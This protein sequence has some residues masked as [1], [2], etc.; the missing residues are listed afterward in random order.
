VAIALIGAGGQL[1]GDLMEL[2]AGEEVFAFARDQLDLRTPE[3]I[4]RRLDPLNIETV[5]NTAAYNLV[6]RAESA[7]LEAFETNYVGAM[8]LARYC[9]GRG[10]RLVHFSTD[11]VFGLDAE[12]DAPWEVDDAPGPVSVYGAS[13]LAG[14]YAVRT[15]ASNHLVVRTCGLYGRRG[16]RG[17]GGNFVETMLRLAESGKPL[18]IVDDQTCTPSYTTDVAEATI[19]L[20]SSDARG[21]VH[22]TNSGCCTWFEFAQEIFRQAGKRVDCQP[23]RSSEYAAAARRPA[24]SVLSLERL[25]AL[26]APAPPPWQDAVARYL[27]RRG[28]A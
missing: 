15:Y 12:R 17:K 2:L 1:A 4:A 26:G 13:K 16:S 19:R 5:V 3:A 27:Q 28:A 20:L 6:D 24:Y 7:P 10:L 14:E 22:A 11:Y 25:Q 18:R 9:G 23:I 8:H 21:I